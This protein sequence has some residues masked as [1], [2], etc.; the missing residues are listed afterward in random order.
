MSYEIKRTHYFYTNVSDVPGEAY[1]LLS[2]LADLGISLQAFTSM[3]I[4]PNL[5]QFTLFP[6]DAQQ[7]RELGGKA[8]LE[9]D[10][11]HPALLVQGDD[12]LGALSGIH[13]RLYEANVN[14]YASSGVTS[15]RGSYGYIIYVRPEQFTL[16]SQALNV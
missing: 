3:P 1:K 10:G 13:E 8:G 2:L 11:P 12:V 6:A 15:G 16:A 9:L 7:L 4:G 5:T 14:V